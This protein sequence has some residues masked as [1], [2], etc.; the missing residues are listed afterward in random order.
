MPRW[1]R[2]ESGALGALLDLLLLPAEGA[3][4][5]IVGVR[6]L[7]YQS[8][9][10]H[11][12]TAVIPVLSI[13]NISVGGTGKTPICAFV[14]A[15]LR[16]WGHRPAV[17]LRGYGRDEVEVHRELNPHIPVIIAPRRFEGVEA[18]QKQ[19]ADCVV[20]DDGFQHRALAR[21]ADLVLIAAE[22]WSERR[23]LLP[24]G[25]W[26]EE[27]GALRRA[28]F[29]LI[30]RKTA[31]RERAMTIAD[32]LV[33]RGFVAAAGVA[34]LV[35]EEVIRLDGGLRKPLT[36][37]AGA[38]VVAV[39]TLADPAPVLEQ[40]LEFGA[41]CELLDFPDHHDFTEADLATIE[42]RAGERMIIVTRK[43]AVKLRGRIPAGRVWVMDQRVEVEAGGESL[44]R[45][46]R[47]ALKR[48]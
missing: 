9:A 31:S 28:D 14:A 48:L 27:V 41:A 21:D 19:G 1:W 16:D 40:L 37:L 25:P 6:N 34:H 15:Q 23:R 8:G 2:G 46:L 42:S 39:T 10:M 22:S 43:E 33:Q 44:D 4:R 32:D 3:F 38:E 35:S 12:H 5:V 18:A 7:L 17:V 36:S 13:G 47:R 11:A 20:L 26:R 24:R 45:I 29:L 30:T